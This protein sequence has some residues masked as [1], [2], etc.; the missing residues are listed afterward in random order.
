M[1]MYVFNADGTMQ[2]ANPDAGD[3][4]GSDSDGKGIWAIDGSGVRGKWIE[5][6]ADRNTHRYTGRGE[7]S[8]EISVSDNRLSGSGTM[9]LYDA[10]SMPSGAIPTSFTGD[11][12]TLSL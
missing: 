3:S 9:R 2:Q 6:M 1:H 11:R 7:Y 12:V 8:F 4:H 10:N 5:V